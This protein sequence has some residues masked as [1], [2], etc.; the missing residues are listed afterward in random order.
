MLV[1][2]WAL[3]GLAILVVLSVGIW[4]SKI[5]AWMW[6]TPDKKDIHIKLL[7]T[8]VTDLKAE[9]LQQKNDFED[10]IEIQANTISSL[11]A[12]LSTFQS[13]VLTKLMT[14]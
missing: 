3:L 13:K 12:E 6:P 14:N 10:R 1:P 9:Q 11:H 5:Q 8:Q 4:I 2:E 7:E